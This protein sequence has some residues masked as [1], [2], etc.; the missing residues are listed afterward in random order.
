VEIRA[1]ER[2]IAEIRAT[3]VKLIWA[4]VLGMVVI[5]LL[6]IKLATQSEII[7]NQTPGMPEHAVI[8]KTAMDKGAQKATLSAV[9]SAIAQVNPANYEYVKPMIQAFLA[10]AAFTK[11]SAE[12]D[13][14][15]Q[16]LILQRELGSYYFVQKAYEYDAATD[17]HFIV[18][19]VHTVNAAKDTAATYVFEYAVHVE[20]YRLVVDEAVSYAGDRPHDGE[21]LK[22]TKR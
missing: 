21:W 11:V 15:V 8:E 14:K 5:L 20:N 3:N 12:I 2:S 22:A 17:R 4:N 6:A 7:I 16:K 1:R 19:D 18:G 10:P 13:A 9:T